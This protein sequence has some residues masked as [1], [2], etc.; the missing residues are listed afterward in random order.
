MQKVNSSHCSGRGVLIR[1]LIYCSLLP[2]AAVLSSPTLHYLSFFFFPPTPKP[3]WEDSCAFQA[4]TVLISSTVFIHGRTISICLYANTIMWWNRSSTWRLSPT[5][6]LPAQLL[7]RLNKH[8]FMGHIS[9]GARNATDVLN[10][11]NWTPVSQY[12]QAQGCS[13]LGTETTS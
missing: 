12:V 7:F 5:N 13:Y 2:P 1:N 8:S 4:W 6:H 9:K 11:T 10:P 3:W